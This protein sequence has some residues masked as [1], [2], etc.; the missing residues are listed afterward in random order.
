MEPMGD[1]DELAH[2]EEPPS[3]R[4]PLVTPEALALAG[5]LL[6]LTSPLLGGLFQFLGFLLANA[7]ADVQDHSW[8]Y[9]FYAA[10][11]A[12]VAAVGAAFGWRSAR[13]DVV[14]PWARAAA[15]AAVLA[16]T[17]VMVIVAVGILVAFVVD[18]PN[19]SF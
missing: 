17:V 5:L 2:D 18:D 19:A 6:V 13:A 1:A 8:Q 7:V 11:T 10:P 9:V 14:A 12:V 16:A 4:P 15:G 3:V